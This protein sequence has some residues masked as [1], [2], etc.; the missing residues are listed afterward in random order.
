NDIMYTEGFSTYIEAKNISQVLEGEIRPIHFR[1]VC[2]V[3]MK[4]FNISLADYGFFG[5][6]DFQQVAVLKKMVKELNAPIKLVMCP[7][8]RDTDGLAMSSRNSYLSPKERERAL[9]INKALFSAKDMCE[10][11]ETDI[12]I[13][14]K[15][16]TETIMKGSPDAVDYINIYDA[17][18]LEKAAKTENAV[19]LIACRYGNTRLIDNMLL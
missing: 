7:I 10:K 4:L 13:L 6:K 14:R 16:L 5:Q 12:N 17:D 15:H 8:I 18:T 9:Y 3:C 1:G 19:I 2:T 11:G